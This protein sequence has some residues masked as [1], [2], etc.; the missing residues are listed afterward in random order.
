M[1][2]ILQWAVLA[3]C[4]AVALLRVPDAVRGRNRTTFGIVVLS[5][6]CILL[7]IPAPYEGIDR[8]LGGWNVT[9]LILRYLVVATVLL[10]GM[11]I[12]RGL[13]SARSYA[14]ITGPAG[15][16]VLLATLGCLTV[17]FVLLDTRGSS[18]GLISLMDQDGRNGALAPFYSAAGRAYP[19]FVSIALMPALLKTVRSRLPRLVRAGAALVLVGSL[20]AAVSVPFSFLPADATPGRYLVN[21]TAVLGFV[22]GL[23]F[24]WL[25]GMKA[26]RQRNVAAE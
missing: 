10:L 12:A 14:L 5:A 24:F 7:T 20:S 17:L 21:Y 19:A 23:M 15:R 26:Q 18:A 22:L 8:L 2:V 11:R 25:S 4:V 16:W 3:V 13:G 1:T 6:L 9:N